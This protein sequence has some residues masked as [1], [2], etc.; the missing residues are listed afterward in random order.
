MKSPVIDWFRREA[1]QTLAWLLGG[2][3]FLTGNFFAFIKIRK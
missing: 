3:L 2:V 1:M